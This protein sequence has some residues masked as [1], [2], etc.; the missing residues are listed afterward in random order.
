MANGEFAHWSFVIHSTF[1]IR[2]SS[3]SSI[4]HVGSYDFLNDVRLGAP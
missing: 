4:P 2:I 1:V 3:L